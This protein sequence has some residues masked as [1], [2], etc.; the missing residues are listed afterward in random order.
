MNITADLKEHMH[1]RDTFKITAIKSNDPPGWAKFKRMRNKIDTEIKAAI[2]F[3]SNKFMET[4]GASHQRPYLSK[5][6]QFID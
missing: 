4:S 5:S 2:L 6:H 3:Y 1:N